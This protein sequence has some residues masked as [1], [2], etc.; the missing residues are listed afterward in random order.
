[1]RRALVILLAAAALTALPARAPAQETASA[2]I[3]A[4]AATPPQQ[5][6]RGRLDID[7]KPGYARLLFI[8]PRPTP[9]A[10]SIA[11]GVLTLRLGSPVD[12]TVDQF[13]ERLAGYVTTG[14]RDDDG[15]TYRFAIAKAL[16]LHSSSVLNRTAVDLIPD[17]FKGV[18]PEL[19]PPPPPPPPPA[20]PDVSKLAPLKVRVGEYANFTRLVFDWPASVEYMVYPGR[21]Q[22]SVR[23]QALARPDFSM[24]EQRAP[25]W[26]KNAGWHIDGTTTVVDFETDPESGFHDFRD[27]NKVAIDVLAPKTDGSAYQP[28]GSDGSPV[29]IPITPPPAPKPSAAPSPPPKG[30]DAAAALNEAAAPPAPVAEAAPSPPRPAPTAPPSLSPAQMRAP[31]AEITREGSVLHFPQAKGHAV[32]VFV[33]GETTWIVLDNHPPLDVASLI[34][35]LTG[36]VANAD[37]SQVSGASVLKLMFKTPLMAA[38]TESEL[39]LN[40]AF[41]SGASSSPDAINLTRQGADGQTTLTTPLAGAMRVLALA[42]P[43]AGDHVLVV[44]AR[45]G[46]GMLT[47]KNFVELE[48]LASFAGLAVIPFSDDLSIRVENE[49]VTLSRPQGLA[50]SSSSGA[51]VEPIVQMQQSKEG[52]AFVDFAQWGRGPAAGVYD[53]ERSLRAA[54]AR[55]PESE[56][57]KARLQLARYLLAHDLAAE[58]IGE[59]GMIQ[60]TDAALAN[61]PGLQAMKGAAQVMMARNSDARMSLSLDRLANDPHAALWRGMAEAKL[62]DYGNAR[63]DLLLAKPVLAMYPQALQTR[64]RLARAETGLAQGDLASTADALDQ[65]SSDLSPRDSVEARLYAAELLAAQG[66]VNEAVARLRGLETTDYA[67]VAARATYARVDT[68]LGIKKIKPQEAIDTLENLRFRWRGDD[69]ELK[70]LRKLGSLYFADNRWREGLTTLRIAAVN[71]PN[72]DLARDAQ[73][74]MRKAFTDLFLGGKAD[75]IPPVQA[76]ALYYDFVELTPIGRDGDEMIRRLTDRLVAV[77][78]L[79]PA[80]QLLDHQVNQRLDGVARAV[81]AT[82]LAVIY[83]LDHKPNDAL[84][85]LTATRQTRLPDEI[86]EQRRL[87]EARALAGLKRYDAAVDLIADDEGPDAKRLRADIYWDS[88][89]WKIAGE[90]LEDML[91]NRWNENG[92]LSDAERDLVMRAAVAYSLGNDEPSLDKL[93]DRYA[94]KINASADGKAFA[95]VT[96]RIDRQG[97][98]FRDL[99]KQ[100]ASVDALQAFMDDI[101]KR[102]AAAAAKTASN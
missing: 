97:V 51:N 25:A 83:L 101:K 60:G 99:A 75:T 66:H 32:A 76:L 98:A 86:N 65:L 90:K 21:G 43:D 57:N 2:T 15:L 74:D 1:M 3:P 49:F 10:A 29:A 91:G 80:E 41:T 13:L 50:L 7:T 34:A 62:G 14:R 35:P 81:V 68:L 27:G 82:K 45:P 70:T 92:A 38:V 63:R 69:L 48:A 19:P 17:S 44:P 77:D 53:S 95:V 64:A 89:N 85:T 8:Y 20:A 36:A 12:V 93:R 61:D 24:L 87:L 22:I 40:I 47:P 28:P 11:D 102:G 72:A 5:T 96:E 18:P 84:K 46:K 26:V 88:A 78:L 67:P 79:G 73:D 54:V 9:V 94:P 23:F 16:A 6:A 39:A 42:D 59:I 58:A 31:S 4:A 30:T 33:R 71:F 37:T 56:S 100:I 55:L 52:M